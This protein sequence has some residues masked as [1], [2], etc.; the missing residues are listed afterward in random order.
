MKG[1][2]L[3]IC[4]FA[5]MYISGCAGCS[6]SERQRKHSKNKIEIPNLSTHDSLSIIPKQQEPKIEDS[7][8]KYSITQNTQSFKVIGIID[9]DTY[10]ILDNNKSIRIRM[11]GIDAPEKGM[12]YNKVSKKYLSDLIFDKFIKVR[13]VK[14]DNYGRSIAQT[15]L[16]DGTD[17]SLEMIKA[18]FAWHYKEFSS[19]QDYAKA[20]DEARERQL[21]LWQDKKP[22]APWDVRKLHRN[23]FSTKELFKDSPK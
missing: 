4:L 14:I 13:V 15:Y 5:T 12:P 19:N 20:E 10:D 1:L 22:I 7:P 6:N 23:G 17:I 16:L 2:L 9:G 18:G 8:Q 21:G 11:D 3:L